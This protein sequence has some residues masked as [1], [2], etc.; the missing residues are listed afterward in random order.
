MVRLVSLYNATGAGPAG[1]AFSDQ[2][3]SERQQLPHDLRPHLPGDWMSHFA[4]LVRQPHGL[5]ARVLL[6]T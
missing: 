1:G 3:Q 2:M 6:S 5:S 4:A